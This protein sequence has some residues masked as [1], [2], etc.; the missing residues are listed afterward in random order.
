M[1]L[2]T[3]A[4]YEIADPN[5]VFRGLTYAQWVAV[6]YNNLFSD[7][8]DIVYREGKSISFLRGNVEY[9]YEQQEEPNKS[10]F[11]SL[12]KEQRIRVQEDTAIFVPVI[13]TMFS[14]GDEYQGQVLND[15]LSMRN[16]ARKDTVNGGE[17]GAEIRKYPENAS[18]KLVD[19][20]NEFYVETSLF[21]L[22][23][24][25]NSKIRYSIESPIEA[26]PH[27]ALVVGVFVIISGL[28]KGLYR[29]SFYGKGVGRYLTRSVYDIEVAEGEGA[30]I[31]VSGRQTL[32]GGR[33]IMDFVAN[34]KDKDS[35]KDT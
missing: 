25:E 16:I 26:G 7:K 10:I 14:L 5:S 31:D 33:S 22:S 20:L 4:D 35:T 23:V 24:S 28:K 11:S 18:K 34:W 13:S 30:L 12:T 8:P 27:Q 19:D 29:L 3:M 32:V 9:S 21:P 1:E 2:I 17:I 6:W 15:E